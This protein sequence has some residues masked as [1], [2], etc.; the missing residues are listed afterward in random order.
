MGGEDL[1]VRVVAFAGECDGDGL[2]GKRIAIGTNLIRGE[3]GCGDE[4]GGDADAGG[5]GDFGDALGGGDGEAHGGEAAGADGDGDAFDVAGR[6]AGGVHGL[7][8]GEHEAVFVALL[9]G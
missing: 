1:H 8:D 4:G 3:V 9:G 6:Q 7:I 5:A 2:L